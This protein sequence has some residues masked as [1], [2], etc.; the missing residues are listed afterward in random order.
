MARRI[1][2]P[3][4]GQHLDP[5]DISQNSAWNV[6]LE[7][8]AAALAAER[9]RLSATAQEPPS[10]DD[11]VRARGIVDIASRSNDQT[12][13]EV[14]ID[15]IAAALSEQRQRFSAA[16]PVLRDAAQAWERLQQ[17]YDG[18]DRE[19]KESGE[20]GSAHR[21]KFEAW[22]EALVEN[23]KSVL[24]GQAAPL[25][26]TA[27]LLDPSEVIKAARE[28]RDAIDEFADDPCC[29][30]GP[31]H[32]RLSDALAKY[33]RAAAAPTA[34]GTEVPREPTVGIGAL[35]DPSEEMVGKV[36]LAVCLSKEFA[37]A[38]RD[39]TSG[40][41]VGAGECGT[42]DGVARAALRAA[43]MKITAHE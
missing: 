38:H 30:W 22:L 42:C 12:V 37:C 35:L 13:R 33:D 6:L 7:E 20:V 9:Q 15:E 34:G 5:G 40:F 26:S 21:D 2:R 11:L 36:A 25:I 18:Q 41:P 10:N 17:M 27:V 29:G 28:A 3:F 24:I 14:L 1:L 4:V 16:F 19:R 23:A 39:G 32:K 8:I 43:A 31:L